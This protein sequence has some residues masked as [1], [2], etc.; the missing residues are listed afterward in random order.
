MDFKA[1][2]KNLKK[3]FSGMK[4]IKM[5]I[6]ADWSVQMLAQA[7]RG[8][9]YEQKLD[10]RI[11]EAAYDQMEAE[12]LDPDS[13]LYAFRPDYVLLFPCAETFHRKYQ[14]LGEQERWKA[15]KEEG[16]RIR[17]LCAGIEK[18]CG[19]GILLANECEIRDGIYGN[20]A[21]YF[22]ESYL[23]QQ[24]ELNGLIAA[25]AE[26][27]GNRYLIDILS[28][29]SEYGRKNMFD[30]RLYYLSKTVFRMDFL[31]V[32][33]K[34]IVSVMEVLNGKIR[35][36]LVTDLDNTLWGGVIGDDGIEGI[37]VGNIG[38][39]PAYSDLQTWIKELSERGVAVAVCSKN[40]DN[41]AREPFI[42]LKEMVLHLEDISVFL[43]NWDDKV[44]NIKKIR[45][46]L[47]IGFDS[48]VFVDDNVFERDLVRQMLPDVTVPDLPA[49]PTR[50][51]SALQ[52]MSLF[53]TV[54]VSKED[55]N[56]TRLYQEE[57]R[58]NELRAEISDMD[59]Y[60]RN[61][62][63]QAEVSPFSHFSAPRIAQLSQRSNQFN[64][65]TRRY[66]E[67]DIENMIAD[68]KRYLTMAVDLKDRFGEY[69]IISV[70]ILS[71]I[72]DDTLFLDTMLM[73]CR[74]LKRTV[75]E[76]IFNRIVAECRKIGVGKILAEYLPTPKNVMVRDLLGKYDFEKRETEGPGEQWV[77]QIEKYRE[78]KTFVEVRDEKKRN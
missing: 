6:V 11:Y 45:Q 41:T 22:P 20:Y 35:K 23:Y 53:E 69:G 7:V 64:L 58:R 32:V 40:N 33:A 39:G 36:C 27:D 21:G 63:M 17:R 72:D 24:R 61:L 76:F 5:A 15:A 47:N 48:M 60:L 16:D 26:E 51:L 52:E 37:Q 13:Q 71:R 2:R 54:T 49:D 29:Q 57:A 66:T 70:V 55:R 10:I 68:P 59:D 14:V 12:L 31:P 4:Q 67:Q 50:Y 30:E 62:R 65:R 73:S 9:G 25:L 28:L 74:V 44:S 75:E 78:K 3:N 77:L 38:I 34:E 56:R 18:N 19:A 1:L 42:K 46:I 8:Y 43:A